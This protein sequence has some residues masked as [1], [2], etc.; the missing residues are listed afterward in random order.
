MSNKSIQ[1]HPRMNMLDTLISMLYDMVYGNSDD[2]QT[3]FLDASDLN[4]NR[5][6]M[7]NYDLDTIFDTDI[8]YIKTT[9]IGID[10]VDALYFK[11]VGTSKDTTIEIVEYADKYVVNNIN[12][13]INVNKVIRTLLSELV[14]NKKTRHILLPIINV[15]ATGAELSKYKAL[16]SLVDVNKIYSVSV[17]EHFY[18]TMTLGH[19]LSKI[20][21]TE[22]V[23]EDI[24]FRIVDVLYVISL[25][26]PKFKCNN[27]TPEFIDCYVIR[28]K[29]IIFPYIKLNNFYLAEI[30]DIINND[31]EIPE[32]GSNYSYNDLYQFLNSLWHTHQAKIS[33]YSDLV[34]I[35][36]ALL[37]KKIRNPNAQFLT[38]EMWNI[39]SDNERND[40]NIRN[41]RM[42]L[43]EYY[44]SIKNQN[45]N[46]EP[47]AEDKS[48]SKAPFLRDE[49]IAEA[50]ING[51]D[52][53]I[54]KKGKT[55]IIKEEEETDINVED[56]EEFDDDIIE[57]SD[58][59]DDE[60]VDIP[61]KLQTSEDFDDVIVNE[62]EPIS[63]ESDD[64]IKEKKSNNIHIVNM[65][66]KN[67]QKT[68]NQSRIINVTD[69]DVANLKR[70]KVY[71][72]RRYINP[73]DQAQTFK[74][75][76]VSHHEEQKYPRGPESHQSK[77][78]SIGNFL[79]TNPGDFRSQNQSFQYGAEMGHQIPQQMPQQ[80]PQQTQ[81]SQQIPQMSPHMDQNEMMQRYMASLG[82]QMSQ[83][84]PQMDSQ[85]MAM[86]QQQQM[87]QQQPQLDPQM[88]AMLQQQQQT[89]QIPQ[90]GGYNKNFFFRQ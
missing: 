42:K 21:L 5:F 43:T 72:G 69:S 28:D 29:G 51:S 33:E 16:K 68:L 32:M 38:I 67:S 80:M 37:P 86:L 45:D 56:I 14:V 50:R 58:S 76:R 83:Q 63:S 52:N 46:S 87:A 41:V 60:S 81:M 82:T 34:Q 57:E 12:N 55:G 30:E 65:S 35:F 44:K 66:K 2:Y 6:K 54:T 4:M 17:I 10:N 40:L 20:P 85:M 23:L 26:Y 61:D 75:S 24:I 78:N 22:I 49:P 9:P 25:T 53:G 73:P 70:H 8:T 18:K 59:S 11:R 15:D 84:Q 3:I 74:Q 47:I 88:L 89:P 1:T 79:G 48:S 36:D 77:M 7:A 13:P 71:Q 62:D 19:L 39:L 31:H 27:L 90:M 64:E